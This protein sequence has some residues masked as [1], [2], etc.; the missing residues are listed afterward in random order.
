M[1]SPLNRLSASVVKPSLCSLFVAHLLETFDKFD[2]SKL[3][4]LQTFYVS[5]EMR[6]PSLDGI[7]HVRS[8]KALV[9][10]GKAFLVHVFKLST[11]HS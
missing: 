1:R 10:Y 3:D 9:Q 11:N 4:F 5:P 7:L 2:S 6:A 8:D